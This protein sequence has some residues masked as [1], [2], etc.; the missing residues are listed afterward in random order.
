MRDMIE[1]AVRVRRSR[2]WHSVSPSQRTSHVKEFPKPQQTHLHAYP[3]SRP[4][5]PFHR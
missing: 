2:N 5:Y 4:F 3:T 1:D